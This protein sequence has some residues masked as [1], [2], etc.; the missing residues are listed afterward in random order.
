MTQKQISHFEGLPNCAAGHRARHI[1]DLRGPGAGAGG[2]HL[3]ECACRST[4]KHANPDKAIE[5]WRR[6]NRPPQRAGSSPA[7][8]RRQRRAVQP[9]PRGTADG[10]EEGCGRR[11]WAP[12]KGWTS[13][14]RIG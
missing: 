3:V 7:C 14:G 11:P 5:A 10:S 6:L 12:L 1:H 2:G 13:P 4:S 9:Q 8:R